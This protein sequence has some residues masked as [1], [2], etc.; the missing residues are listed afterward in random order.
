MFW[1][2]DLEWLLFSDSNDTLISVAEKS[3]FLLNYFVS[4][5]KYVF[6]NEVMCNTRGIFQAQLYILVPFII[7]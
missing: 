4:K 7:L 1:N 6:L 2:Y 5:M 3:A